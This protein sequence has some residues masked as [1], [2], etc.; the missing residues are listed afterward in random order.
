MRNDDRLF[1]GHIACCMENRRTI[2][3]ADERDGD[4][5][6]GIEKKDQSV[7]TDLTDRT[8]RAGSKLQEFLIRPFPSNPL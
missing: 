6:K 7:I 5:L 1:V 2:L 3:R 8:E 4:P